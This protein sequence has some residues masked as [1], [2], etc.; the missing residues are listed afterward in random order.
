[1]S[2][3]GMNSFHNEQYSPDTDENITNNNAFGLN[4][5]LGMMLYL[6]L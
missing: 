1:M 5:D 2:I 4:D 3:S 6:L